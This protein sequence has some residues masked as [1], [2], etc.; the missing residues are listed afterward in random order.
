MLRAELV[1]ELANLVLANTRRPLR[2]G[3]DGIDCAGKTTLADELAEEIRRRGQ[4][5]IRASID[6]FHMPREYRLRQG[7]YS[8]EGYFSDSFDYSALVHDLLQ[9]LGPD[10][11]G[12]FRARRFNFR[13]DQMAEDEWQFADTSP[14]LI[15]DG[16]FMFREKLVGFWDLRIFV[17]ISFEESL[18]RAK[19]RDLELFGDEAE[20]VRK[21]T[22]RYMPGQKLYFEADAPSSKAHVVVHNNDPADASITLDHTL[23]DREGI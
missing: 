2:V 10:G 6:G 20:L 3:I 18:S 23:A 7:V 21:Y 17:E 5:V 13:S 4:N 19:E 15:M 1:S 14:I 22:M 8:P 12:R 16:V 11:D 9:P